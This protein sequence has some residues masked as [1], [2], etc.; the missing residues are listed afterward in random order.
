VGFDYM[1]N[2]RRAERGEIA[3]AVALINF[4]SKTDAAGALAHGWVLLELQKSMGRTK[5][6]ISLSRATDVGR[7]S[8]LEIMKVAR[9]YK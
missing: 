4:S 5:F 3:A 7:K 8:A 1:G 9:T 6:S 2:L